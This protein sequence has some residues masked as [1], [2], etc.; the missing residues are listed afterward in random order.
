MNKKWLLVT[1]AAFAAA[2]LAACGDSEKPAENTGTETIEELEIETEDHKS[3]QSADEDTNVEES[4]DK[5][6]DENKG[7]SEEEPVED[8]TEE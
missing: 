3:D 7:T 2:V 6:N 8:I 4:S 5:E 1:A